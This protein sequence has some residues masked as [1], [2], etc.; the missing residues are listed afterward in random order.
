MGSVLGGRRSCHVMSALVCGLDVHKDSTYATILD[1]NG[2]IV[3]QTRMSNDRVLS[4][5]SHFSVGKVAVVAAV[6]KLL[7]C[8]YSVLKNKRPYY[9]QA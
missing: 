7:M 3:N 2:K 9:D 4:Y 5:L 6:R 1:S 8:C